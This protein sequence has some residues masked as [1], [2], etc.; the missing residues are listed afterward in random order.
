MPLDFG[1]LLIKFSIFI[2]LKTI[3]LNSGMKK[4]LLS[5]L[6]LVSASAFA[7]SKNFEGFSASAAIAGGSKTVTDGSIIRTNGSSTGVTV[8]ESSKSATGLA[9]G[10]AY[11]LTTGPLLTTVGVDYVSGK[12]TVVNTTTPAGNG[13]LSYDVGQRM[14]IYVA[15]GFMLTNEALAY[16]KLGYASFSGTAVSAGQDAADGPGKSGML[17][18]LGFKQKFGQGSPFHFFADYTA[19]TTSSGRTSTVPAAK[20]LDNKVKFSTLSIGVGYSF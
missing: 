20:Y 4:L 1:L 12:S 2:I 16:V 3:N 14:D 17:W 15:P 18:G 5:S 6:V 10:V 7:Q 8:V 19:G 13:T 11:G 9:L